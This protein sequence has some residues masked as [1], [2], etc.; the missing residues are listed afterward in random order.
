MDDTTETTYPEA[1]IIDKG[2]ETPLN[3]EAKD[4]K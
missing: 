1:F 2:V 4:E 3:M